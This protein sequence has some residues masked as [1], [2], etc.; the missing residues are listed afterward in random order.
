VVADGYHIP[1]DDLYATIGFS[2]L[3]ETFNQIASCIVQPAQRGRFD[4]A[5]TAHCGRSTAA[6]GRRSH[7]IAGER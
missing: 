5:S 3:I 1:K 2:V 4:S 6:S 7:R